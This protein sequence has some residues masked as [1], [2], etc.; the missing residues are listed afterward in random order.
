[1]AF[2]APFFNKVPG[3]KVSAAFAQIVDDVA[4]CKEGPIILAKRGQIVCDECHNV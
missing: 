1:V 4:V 3:V 2:I